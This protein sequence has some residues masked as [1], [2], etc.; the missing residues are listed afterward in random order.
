MTM[1]FAKSIL[2]INDSLKLPSGEIS[3]DRLRGVLACEMT[4]LDVEY[5]QAEKYVRIE[6]ADRGLII[7]S[8]KYYDLMKNTIFI[9]III[10]LLS[11]NL[12]AIN[13]VTMKDRIIAT[14]SDDLRRAND[15]IYNNI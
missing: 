13:V 5:I 4:R 11:I 14:K 8:F 3:T 12:Q 10:V 7:G 15:C 6:G 2:F 1:V 9:S